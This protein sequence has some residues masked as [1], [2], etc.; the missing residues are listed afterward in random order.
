MSIYFSYYEDSN[1]I[2]HRVI[3][4]L[5]LVNTYKPLRIVLDTQQVL[6]KSEL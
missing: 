6:S 2:A 1:S 3:V 4:V 5:K